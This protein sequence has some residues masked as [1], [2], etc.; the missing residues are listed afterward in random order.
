VLIFTYLCDSYKDEILTKWERENSGLKLDGKHARNT[1]LFRRPGRYAEIRGRFT[2]IPMFKV[3]MTN[4]T[5]VLLQ[6]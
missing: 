6:Q 5:R 3:L 4:L 2:D 1:S